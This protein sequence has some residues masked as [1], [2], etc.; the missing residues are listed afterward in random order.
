MKTHFTL[1]I[2]LLSICSS[3][4]Q[5]R[6]E[7]GYF[8]NNE[9]QVQDCWIKNVDW[10][11]NPTQF[12]YKLSETSEVLTIDINSVK[13]FSIGNFIKYIRATIKIDK[14]SDEI[15]RL[16]TQRNPIWSEQQVFLKVLVQSKASLYYYEEE[17]IYRYFF[18]VDDMP[19]QQLV[20]KRYRVDG[21]E[22]KTN[23]D[24]RQQLFVNV[25]CDKTTAEKV[26][27]IGYNRELIDYFEKFNI[28]QGQTVTTNQFVNPPARKNFLNVRAILGLDYTSLYLRNSIDSRLN[29]DFGSQINFR[30]GLDFAFVLPFNNN[31]WEIFLQPSLSS[32]NSTKMSSREEIRVEY[33]TIELPIGLRHHLFLTKN[34]SIF[35]NGMVSPELPGKSAVYSSTRISFDA[36]EINPRLNFGFGAGIG[37]KK[38]HTELRYYTNKQIL[39]SYLSY[40]T[41]FS[42]FTFILGYKFNRDKKD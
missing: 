35:L 5:T 30:F 26:K 38:F 3:L 22:V 34:L 18:K 23:E 39:G 8:V 12:D 4:A 25:N 6:F 7:K 33:S 41:T 36:L 40:D 37:Y 2:I 11:N 20:Y 16:S 21:Y 24:F 29:T 9:N 28:C 14:S 27:R 19:I 17:L 15:K 10:K 31:K 32:F 1:L 13:E 42:K